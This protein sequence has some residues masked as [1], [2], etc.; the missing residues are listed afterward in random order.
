MVIM[1]GIK[2]RL[3]LPRGALGSR[4]VATMAA[5][6]IDM[7]ALGPSANGAFDRRMG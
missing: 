2:Q 4:A 7:R 1:V 3:M 5:T 6:P